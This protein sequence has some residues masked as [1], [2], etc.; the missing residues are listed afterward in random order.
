MRLGGLQVYILLSNISLESIQSSPN[1]QKLMLQ[2]FCLSLGL[3][4]ETESA[5]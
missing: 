5:V 1:P 4:N 2:M 3:R